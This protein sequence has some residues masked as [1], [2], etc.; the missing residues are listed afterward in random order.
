MSVVS[1][2]EAFNTKQY[3]SCLHPAHSYVHTNVPAAASCASLFGLFRTVY[4][5]LVQNVCLDRQMEH[6][7]LIDGIDANTPLE[8][9]TEDRLYSG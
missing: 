4:M 6:G 1:S 3:V 2:S 7:M 9:V 5:L 8:R